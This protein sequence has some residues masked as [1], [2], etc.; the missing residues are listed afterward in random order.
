MAD[1]LERLEEVLF[2]VEVRGRGPATLK[3]DS[4]QRRA[5]V[6]NA[7]LNRRLVTSDPPPPTL[8]LSHQQTEA[9]ATSACD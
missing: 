5:K 6:C 8:S 4:R 1:M 3:A 2:V 9:A 7:D